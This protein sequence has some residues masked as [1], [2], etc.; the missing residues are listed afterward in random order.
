MKFKKF[1]YG[2]ACIAVLG[3]CSDEMNYHEY[4]N[5]DEDYITDSYT[6]V[7]GLITDIYAKLPYDFGQTYSGAFLGSASDE[8]EY[9]WSS[10]GI[11]DFYNGSWSAINPKSTTWTN[12]YA[13]IQEANMFLDKFQGLTF[14]E[15][16]LNS[17][18][19][20][21]MYRYKNCSNEA[22]FL[23]AFFYFEL[24]RQYGDVPFT[25]SYLTGNE[26]NSLSRTSSSKIFGFI[27][28]TCDSIVDSIPVDYS[29]LGIYALPD[30]S[31]ETA[32]AN[33]LSVLALKGRTALYAA[34]PL[35]N[36]TS[37]S[38][39]WHKAALA[40][41]TVL[42]SCA[43]YGIVLG[44]YS[45][46]WG[47]TNYKN[48]EMIFMRRVGYL[49]S[50]ESYNFPIGVEGGNSGNCPTQNL[51]DAY[52]MQATGKLYN[53]TGSGYDPTNPYVG[54]DPRFYLTIVKNGDTGWP[55]YNALPIQTYTGGVNGSPISGATP[56]GYYLKKYCDASVNLTAASKNTKLHTWIV[57]RLG[58]FYLNYAEAVFKYLGSADAT[59]SEFPMSARQTVNKIRERASM[60]DLPIGLSND[61][62]W[63]KYEN[64]RMVELAFEGHRFWDV[65]RWKEGNEFKSITEMKITLNSDGTYTYTR[66][67]V[68][69]EWDDKMYLFP[70]PKSELLK[71]THLTQN[72]GW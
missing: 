54:R 62:F 25:T 36:T 71:N 72:A 46:L 45:S 41:K 57:Y 24:V 3:S 28:S 17:D 40:N 38:D 16:K 20:A 69:H 27:E 61:D 49:N 29:N 44:T 68:S 42:D 23:R 53:E 34:S 26:A 2:I 4:S 9:A 18:Y 19:E 31:A 33:R 67:A 5:Y 65:R 63:N 13:A 8:S 70:I 12:S 11:Y 58:E 32:R 6:N 22:R 30:E 39:L 10:N 48:N 64:E 60:P 21:Q 14:P 59:S 7:V 51:V 66:N 50:L 35:F 43:K 56:T 52:E 37:S 1:I 15:L 55:S 47:Q